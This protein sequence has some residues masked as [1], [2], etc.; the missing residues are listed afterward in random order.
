MENDAFLGVPE[1]NNNETDISTV[2]ED[3]DGQDMVK[4]SSSKSRSSPRTKYAA[5]QGYTK[6]DGTRVRPHLRRVKK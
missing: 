4:K 1:E 2:N 5:V 3:E 6:S